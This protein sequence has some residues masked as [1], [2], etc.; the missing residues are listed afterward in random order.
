MTM[1]VEVSV[2]VERPA[3]EVFA[4]IT[5]FE[6]NPKWQSGMQECTFTTEPP[7]R[8]GSRYKQ[9]AK[10]MGQRIESAFEVL[11]YEPNRMIRFH[12]TSGTFPIRIMRSVE[13]VGTAT[14]VTAI[15]EGEPDGLLKW[16]TPITRPMMENNIKQ[17][18]QRLKQL[19]ET[20]S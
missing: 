10:F 5:N 12:S 18:Y 16:L 20:E 9:V 3:D 13:P 2:L 11:E 4:Y 17:D 8:V 1:R 19:L 7:L 6:N 14:K 15:I